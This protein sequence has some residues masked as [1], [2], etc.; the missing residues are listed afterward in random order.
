MKTALIFDTETTGL[1]DW[2]NPSGADHQ[3]HLVQLAAILCDLETATPIQSMD[4]I[5]RPD[6]W[7]IPQE[8]TEIHGI[9]HEKALAI[10]IPEPLA[11]DMFLAMWNGCTR[12]AHNR[13]FD[14]RIIRI[15][16]KR[17]S[18]EEVIEAWADKEDF[19]CTLMMSRKIMGGKNGHTLPEAYRHFTGNELVG[20]H[21]AM[22]DAQGCKDIY[23]AMRSGKASEQAA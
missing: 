15:A 5:I 14:Q 16:A 17:Y 18:T 23:F 8:V 3:P 22:A 19:E 4:V 13:T 11:L 20:A 1:P 12:V 9:S 7:T 21:S 6:H 10:G 2:K